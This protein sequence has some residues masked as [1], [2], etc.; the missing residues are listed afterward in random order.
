[1]DREGGADHGEA[2]VDEIES[3]IGEA[4]VQGTLGPKEDAT[5]IRHRERERER[6]IAPSFSTIAAVVL[7]NSSEIFC[8]L[9]F[10]SSGLS[11]VCRAAPRFPCPFYSPSSTLHKNVFRL[12]EHKSEKKQ[13]LTRE[14]LIGKK[15]VFLLV[16]AK[17]IK[18]EIFRNEE[19]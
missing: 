19:N 14:K 5:T 1:M 7:L 6:E 18:P 11:L 9:L 13:I 15:H 8:F 16:F 17:D 3:R 12:F 4:A 10:L 2:D